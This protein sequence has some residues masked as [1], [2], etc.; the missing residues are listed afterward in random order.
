MWKV[1]A[2]IS[3][4]V[5]SGQ[6]NPENPFVLVV[7]RFV[8]NRLAWICLLKCFKNLFRLKITWIRN[9]FAYFLQFGLKLYT[10]FKIELVLS[11]LVGKAKLRSP[12][13]VKTSTFLSIFSS[14]FIDACIVNWVDFIFNSLTSNLSA[15]NEIQSHSKF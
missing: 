8:F 10:H 12:F 5:V 2:Y 1:F 15:A 3:G 13:V 14:W 9:N 6:A 4:F 7:L 11:I